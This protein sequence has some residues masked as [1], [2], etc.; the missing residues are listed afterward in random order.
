M[1]RLVCIA[2]IACL[3]SAAHS[4]AGTS[5]AIARPE[6]K[7]YSEKGSVYGNPDSTAELLATLAQGDSVAKLD[8]VGRWYRVKLDDGTKG[9]VLQNDVIPDPNNEAFIKMDCHLAEDT[10]NYLKNRTSAQARDKRGY[11]RKGM[12]ARIL[13]HVGS[14]SRIRILEEGNESHPKAGQV[15]WVKY[16]FVQQ[17]GAIPTGVSSPFLYRLFRPIDELFKK[18]R[19][20][21]IFGFFFWLLTVLSFPGALT[22]VLCYFM[23]GRIRV[24]PNWVIATAIVLLLWLVS[25]NANRVLFGV[26]PFKDHYILWQL[27]YWAMFALWMTSNWRLLHYLRCPSCHRINAG[28]PTG[29]SQTGKEHHSRIE[30]IAR[31][32]LSGGTSIETREVDKQTVFTFQDHRRCKHCGH[33]WKVKRVETM[34][35]HQ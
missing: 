1:I 32:N 19:I 12:R 4:T 21:S 13:E 2:G 14:F 15:G 20:L 3:L 30:T 7:V 33:T 31:P 10:V 27:V 35:G 24:L 23:L 16:F 25:L 9:W 17:L 22:M 34:F 6:A 26:P 29:T 8:I 5:V 18:N 11:L 28:Y